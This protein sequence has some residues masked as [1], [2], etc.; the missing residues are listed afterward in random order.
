MQ[1]TIFFFVLLSLLFCLSLQENCVKAIQNRLTFGDFTS[2]FPGYKVGGYPR[3]YGCL[4]G[5]LCFSNI[6]QYYA[7]SDLV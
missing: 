1:K 6:M 7:Y 5:F 3:K 2:H 4:K